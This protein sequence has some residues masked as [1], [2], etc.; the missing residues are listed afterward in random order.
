M[1]SLLGERWKDVGGELIREVERKLDA[2]ELDQVADDLGGL[3]LL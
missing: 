2:S 1:V 3:D